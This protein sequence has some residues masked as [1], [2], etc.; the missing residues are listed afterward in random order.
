MRPEHPHRAR[1]DHRVKSR[2]NFDRVSTRLRHR[3]LAFALGLLI[4]VACSLSQ[5]A[6]AQ[7]PVSFDFS[8]V[9]LDPTYGDQ[10][11]ASVTLLSPNDIPPPTG[12]ISYAVDGGQSATAPLVLNDQTAAAYFN[13][14]LLPPG[15]HTLVWSYTGDSNN[16]AAS[17]TETLTVNDMP[18]SVVGSS[19]QLTPLIYTKVKG[20]GYGSY[21]ASGVAVDPSGNVFLSFGTS[22]TGVAPTVGEITAGLDYKVLPVSG[23]GND[24][25]LA[26]DKSRNLYIA[27][28]ANSRVVEYSA[29]GV[30]TT[31]GISGLQIGRAHV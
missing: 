13:V 20:N 29:S 21:G 27:D 24:T 18:T 9:P 22:G 26:L 15:A 19:Y 17:G 28:P 16:Q 25:Q 6:H 11:Q 31:L 2:L 7:S 30:Q 1:N 23:L 5:S 12:A 4:W 3:R 8:H 14:G 10:I